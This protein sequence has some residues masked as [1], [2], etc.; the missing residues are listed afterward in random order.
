LLLLSIFLISYAQ[1]TWIRVN[2][3][4]YLQNDIK[5]AVWVS[6]EKKKCFKF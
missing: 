6:K 1:T 5:V 3:V 2:Q 4:G